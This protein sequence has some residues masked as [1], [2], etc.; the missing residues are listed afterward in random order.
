MLKRFA[1]TIAAGAVVSAMSASAFAY[2]TKAP[3][4]PKTAIKT[5]TV[6]E[7]LDSPWA[8]AFLGDGRIA[9]TEKPGRL[10]IVSADGT[11]SDPV[12]GLPRIAEVGQ[13]GLLDVEPGPDFA[14]SGM[15][16]LSFAQARDGGVATA[17]ARGRLVR[18]GDGYTLE[19]VET[20]FQQ[21]P[22]LGG[23][24][25]FGSRLVFA[26][27]GKLF[28]TTGDRGE[29][30][31]AQDTSNTIAKVIRVNPDGS[32]PDDNPFVG[33]DGYLPEIFSIGH[34]NAQGAAINPATGELW[35]VEHGARGGD[36][37]N[38][39][40]AGRNYGWPVIS[41]GRHYSGRK[42]GDGQAKAGLE[43]PLYYWDPS[44][45][46]SGMAFYQGDLF[47]EWR[48]SVFVGALKSR[49]LVRLEISDGKIVARERLLTNLGSRIR[50]VEV[51]PD[52]AV[53]VV[54]D[55]SDGKIVKIEPAS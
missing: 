14:T 52:G 21:Q 9:V 34:R 31:R 16:Y 53:Y 29:R 6:V 47:P 4:A 2:Q 18:S 27:D 42:I 55:S 46:P 24:R 38:V 3:E 15:I 5:T 23:G 22:A 45:A 26:P 51:G 39:P 35:T 32:V 49:M 7:G 41:Y 33:R 36:E 48:N 17:A 25:H 50:A 11:L 12:G 8:M 19:N 43:Q 20:I 10:R 1:T 28:I 44:I 13:G 40:K 30:S 37:I 54:T